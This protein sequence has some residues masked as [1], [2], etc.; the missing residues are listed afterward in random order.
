M[1]GS[2]SLN[3][4]YEQVEGQMFFENR[5]NKISMCLYL[6]PHDYYKNMNKYAQKTRITIWKFLTLHGVNFTPSEIFTAISLNSEFTV[7]TFMRAFDLWLV[8][9]ELVLF[10]LLDYRKLFI[11]RKIINILGISFKI[12][13]HVIDKPIY[14]FVHYVHN[15]V[16]YS[17]HFVLSFCMEAGLNPHWWFSKKPYW[18]QRP[19]TRITSFFL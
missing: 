18:L 2:Y 3:K 8:R 7:T 9:I 11:F 16:T 6:V 1:W 19:W 5:Y 4:H 10:F 13:I 14:L 12:L 17:L 15:L